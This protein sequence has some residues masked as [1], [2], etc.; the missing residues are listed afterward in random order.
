MS[1]SRTTRVWIALGSNLGDRDA[2]LSAAVEALRATPDLAV[3]RVSPLLETEPVGGPRGQACYLNG[4]L[5]AETQLTA[6]ELLD[7]LQAIEVRF[8]RDR[9]REERNGPR[10]LDLD[11]LSFGAERI[12]EPDLVVPHPRMEERVFVLEP[13]ARLAPEERLASGRTVR[14]RLR[15]LEGERA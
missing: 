8:G 11:L 4:V 9:V 6:R 14:E 7:V 12:R 13:M 10:T 5:L 15:E 2:T 3:R 1:V